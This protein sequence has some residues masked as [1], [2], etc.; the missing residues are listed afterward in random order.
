MNLDWH[1]WAG[2]IG[3]AAIVLAYLLLQAGRLQGNRLAYQLLNALGALGVIVS[4][5]IAFRLP[6]LLLALA[7]LAISVYGIARNRGSRRRQQ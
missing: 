2:V 7:W 5:L 4:L 1:Q 3:V 6:Q